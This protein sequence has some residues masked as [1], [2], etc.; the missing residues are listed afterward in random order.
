MTAQV[1]DTVLKWSE[2]GRVYIE[3][4]FSPADVWGKQPRYYVSGR[5]NGTSF[6][7]SL[8]ASD[9]MYVLPVNKALQKKAS[10]KVGDSVT[11]TIK[12]AKPQETD[13][14]DELAQAL[15]QNP[16]ARSFFESLTVV[17]KN[18]YLDWVAEAEGAETRSQRIQT[19]LENLAA[20]QKQR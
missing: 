7:G 19:T 5:L 10:L 12:R 18:S 14:P 16:A 11:V 20:G 2:R 9:G 13:M 4:P 3:I 1:F 15:D 17:Q 8:G 6:H